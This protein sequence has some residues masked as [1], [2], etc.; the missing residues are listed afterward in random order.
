MI[1]DNYYSLL[2]IKPKYLKLSYILIILLF[3]IISLTYYIDI[4]DIYNTKGYIECN[5]YCNITF[6]SEI[7]ELAKINDIKYLIIDNNIIDS[8]NSNYNDVESN[9]NINYQKVS[10]N[11]TNNSLSNKTIKELKIYYHK[12][13]IINKIISMFF[14]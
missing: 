11:T 13:K 8:F 12:E 5:E 10:I 4:Y 6:I 2:N 7:D 1:K 9:Q 3:S 14:G